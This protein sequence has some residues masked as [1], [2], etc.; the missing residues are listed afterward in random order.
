[1]VSQPRGLPGGG[2]IA[3]RKTAWCLGGAGLVL[4]GALTFG[5]P[6]TPAADL[7]ERA[8]LPAHVEPAP[9][10][11]ALGGARPHRERVQAGA[12]QLATLF[13]AERAAYGLPALERSEVLDGVASVRTAEVEREFS[14]RRPSGTLGSLLD[15]AG[16]EWEL[17]GEN[18]ARVRAPNATEAAARAHVRF[19]AES[20]HAANVLSPD[21]RYLGVG[22]AQGDG[23]YYFVAVFAR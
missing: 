8:V 9:G 14:H 16:L 7:A 19:M 18:L 17:L 5:A 11:L 3:G 12:D 10:R 13:N 4:L 21:F 22:A 23:S 15:A 1:M 6:I 20:R 2:V